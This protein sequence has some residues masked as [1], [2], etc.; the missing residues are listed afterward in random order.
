MKTLITNYSFS[1]GGKTITFNDYT[2]IDLNRVLL[3]TNVKSPQVII[4]NFA[5]SSLGGTVSGNV[6]S[7]SYNTASMANTDSLQIY[8]DSDE[9][10]AS[11][12]GQWS[13]VNTLK[14]LV[15]AV[16]FPAWY[17]RALGNRINTSAVIESGTVT[18]VTSVTNV[19]ASTL[20]MVGGYQANELA[21]STSIQAWAASNRNLIV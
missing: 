2:T 14:D 20:S 16:A 18:T 21:T 4:Y 10:V 15:N 17:N 5:D 11:Q 9:L 19:A 7:L 12:S 8:Y 13:I 3:I 1:A 6:L